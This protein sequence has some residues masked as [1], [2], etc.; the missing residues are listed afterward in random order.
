MQ[1]LYWYKFSKV[2]FFDKSMLIFSTSNVCRLKA[3]EEKCNY[4]T[5]RLQ[6]RIDNIKI[7]ISFVKISYPLYDI[8]SKKCFSYLFLW[9]FHANFDSLKRSLNCHNFLRILVLVREL[10]IYHNT[11]DIWFTRYIFNWD[12]CSFYSLEINKH[13]AHFRFL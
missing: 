9:S 11:F 5:T 4:A 6:V 8:Y 7:P 1:N 2:N 3:S 13:L 12:Y 10:Y